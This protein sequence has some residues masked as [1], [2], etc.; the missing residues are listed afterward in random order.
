ME[1]SITRGQPCHDRQAVSSA[2]H[3]VPWVRRASRSRSRS[4][5]LD[6]AAGGGVQSRGAR[7]FHGS[8]GV[9]CRRIPRTAPDGARHERR[10]RMAPG[11]SGRP[12]SGADGWRLAGAPVTFG[13][14]ERTV[15]RP[16][17]VA[18]ERLLETAGRLGYRGFELGPPGYLGADARAVH[19]ALA[20]HD[21]E[22]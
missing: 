12:M 21:L 10:R 2:P 13:V 1:R 17:L 14:W 6:A 20:R 9:G 15:D 3:S 5:P 4:T 16:D 22:L 11:R 19:D 18:R 7:T 8:G